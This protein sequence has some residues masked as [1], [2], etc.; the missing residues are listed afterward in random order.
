[1]ADEGKTRDST[2]I[3]NV[4]DAIVNYGMED[5]EPV[6][7]TNDRTFVLSQYH[8]D[9]KPDLIMAYIHL[10][11]VEILRE[12]ARRLLNEGGSLIIAGKEERVIGEIL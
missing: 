12:H 7:L 10:T 3:M 4:I 2:D 1:M 9:H 8:G 6:K 5:S 11:P